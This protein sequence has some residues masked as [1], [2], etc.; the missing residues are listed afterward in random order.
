MSFHEVN[1]TTGLAVCGAGA[2]LNMHAR[3][4][5]ESIGRSGYGKPCKRCLASLAKRDRE[6]QRKA[7]QTVARLHTRTH[8]RTHDGRFTGLPFDQWHYL[9]RATWGM[10]ML[11]V[12]AARAIASEEGRS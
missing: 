3:A 2:A 11:G 8:Q 6:F 9:A 1:P 4:V 5:F 12:A 10:N 7:K